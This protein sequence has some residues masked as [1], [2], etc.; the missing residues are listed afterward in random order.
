MTE[1]KMKDVRDG[2]GARRRYESPR[3]ALYGNL[4]DLTNGGNQNNRDAFAASGSAGFAE[5]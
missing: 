5:P 2:D 4:T 1:P 3:L